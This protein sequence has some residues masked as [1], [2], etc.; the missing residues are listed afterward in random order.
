MN[1]FTAST[2]LVMLHTSQIPLSPV[3]TRRVSAFNAFETYAPETT[4]LN[5]I[6]VRN[7]YLKFY[8]I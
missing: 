2:L 6:L 5:Q 7:F 4:K 3:H 8:R 1:T